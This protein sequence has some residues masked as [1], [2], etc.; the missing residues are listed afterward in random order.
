MRF[1]GP[2]RRQIEI[3]GEHSR[4]ILNHPWVYE[5]CS[6]RVRTDAMYGVIELGDLLTWISGL[7][8]FFRQYGFHGAIMEL[9]GIPPER[10]IPE[11]GRFHGQFVG[12][13]RTEGALSS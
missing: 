5:R 2:L 8:R 6:F 9:V 12:V 4:Y 1:I 10:T 13:A 3:Q 11:T 7:S